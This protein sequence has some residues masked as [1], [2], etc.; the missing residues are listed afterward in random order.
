MSDERASREDGV[1]AAGGG[2]GEAVCFDDALRFGPRD[3]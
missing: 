2:A 1:D 3:E